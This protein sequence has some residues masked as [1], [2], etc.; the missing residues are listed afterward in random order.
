MVRAINEA[1]KGFK[2]PSYEKV[3]TTLVDRE[4]S[5]LEAS[6]QPIKDSWI[7]IGVAIVSGG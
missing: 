4:V 6:M 2:G 7:K 5:N 1:P 3:C